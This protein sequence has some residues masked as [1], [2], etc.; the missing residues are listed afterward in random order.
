MHKF[1]ASTYKE[2]LLLTRDIGGLAILFIMP[3]L[4]L[5]VITLVQDSTFRSIQDVKIP[6]L[7]V[8]ND[9][10]EVSETILG[11]MNGSNAFEVLQKNSE[12]EIEELVSKGEYLLGIVIPENLS[13][14]LKLK[15]DSNVNG[16]L[17][18]FGL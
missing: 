9:K 7:L 12:A 3:L 10:G 18:K 15:V 1:R 14:D 5:I 17:E 13:K 4:L 8:D 16:I 11:N 2:F 6:V